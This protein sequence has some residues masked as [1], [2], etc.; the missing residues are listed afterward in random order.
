MLCNHTEETNS[1][2]AAS[3]ASM[4][5]ALIEV[6]VA[7]STSE[8]LATHRAPR[9]EA[10]SDTARLY[11]CHNGI[12]SSAVENVEAR[13]DEELIALAEQLFDAEKVL[14]ASRHLQKV[15]NRDL[16]AGPH[17]HICKVASE[18]DAAISDLLN[19]PGTAESGWTKQ[20]ESHGRHDTAIYYKV[21][22][23]SKLTC[24][25]ETPIESSLLVPLL[26]VLNESN[27]YTDWCPT[28]T[29]PKLGIR[30]SLQLQ[31][32]GR[33]NQILHVV[34]DIPWPFSP[35][36]VVL[37]TVAVDD[38][39]TSGYFA[40]RLHAG[41]ETGNIDGVEGVLVPP[42]QANVVRVDFEGALLFRP[43]PLD[44]PILVESSQRTTVTNSAGSC[45]NESMILVSFK[46]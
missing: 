33:A 15:K 36:D 35:R 22:G 25:L 40:V 20:G 18:C 24:R 14:E 39:D 44:H 2:E 43:C 21:D 29:I 27:L 13:S 46:M 31:K 1:G 32:I 30:T 34:G 5:S 8:V 3:F 38:I 16:L 4:M 26:S 17:H 9:K 10:T 41:D 37:Q 23:D 7:P 12:R 28:W 45:H 19:E 11:D 42:A 6:T